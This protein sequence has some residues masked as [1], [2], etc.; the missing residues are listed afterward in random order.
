MRT[1]LENPTVSAVNS[2]FGRPAGAARV[3]RWV[4]FALCLVDSA[5]L[6]ASDVAES[7][8]VAIGAPVAPLIVAVTDGTAT[9]SGRLQ[10]LVDADPQDR[11]RISYPAVAPEGQ[12]WVDV[13]LRLWRMQEDGQVALGPAGY[14]RPGVHAFDALGGRDG[15]LLLAV[16]SLRPS[17]SIGDSHIVIESLDGSPSTSWCF[18]VTA[19]RID[20]DADTDRSGGIDLADEVGEADW[21]RGVQG[22]GVIILPNCDR[23]GDRQGPP[24]NWAGGDWDGDG[25]VDAVEEPNGRI[26]GPK[27]LADIGRVVLRRFGPD[28]LPPGLTVQLRLQAVAPDLPFDQGWFEMAFV[29]EEDSYRSDREAEEHSGDQWEQDENGDRGA[30]GDGDVRWHVAEDWPPD[31][32]APDLRSQ[33]RW[34][35]DRPARY[36]VR[37][38]WPTQ[39]SGDRMELGPA[40]RSVLGPEHATD[41]VSLAVASLAGIGEVELGVE[42]IAFGALVDLVLSVRFQGQVVGEDRLRLRVA[43]FVLSDHRQGVGD[44]DLRAAWVHVNHDGRNNRDL[45]LALRQLYSAARVDE[46]AMQ[47]L[48]HQDGYEVGYVKAPYGGMPVVLE[49]ARGVDWSEGESLIDYVRSQVL[50]PGIGVCGDLTRVEHNSSF[51][52]GGNIECMPLG[53]GPGAF[54]YGASMSRMLIAF[55]ATQGVNPL[56]PVDTDWLSVGHIDEV[57][58]FTGQDTA[59][60]ADP[61]TALALL[62]WAWQMQPEAVL[63]IN[64]T[65]DV[66]WCDLRWYPWYDEERCGWRDECD[67]EEEEEQGFGSAG[68]EADVEGDAEASTSR[69]SDADRA[70]DDESDAVQTANRGVAIGEKEGRDTEVQ[71]EGREVETEVGGEV[72][73]DDSFDVAED[74][75]GGW[76][77]NRV[78]VPLEVLLDVDSELRNYNLQTIMSEDELGGVRDELGLKHYASR[79]QP[80]PANVGDL[81]LQRGGALLAWLP[82]SVTRRQYR[83]TYLDTERYRI[84]YRDLHAEPGPWQAGAIGPRNGD[85]TDPQSLAFIFREWWS[86]G[87][88]SPGDAYFFTVRARPRAIPIPVLFHPEIDQA[89]AL[90]ANAVNCILDGTLVI[91][92]LPVGPTVDYRG[93]GR[94]GDI[95]ADYVR[96]AFKRLGMHHVALVDDSAYHDRDGSL[97]CATNVIRRVPEDDWWRYAAPAQSLPFDDT[98]DDDEAVE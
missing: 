80:G 18:A 22:R 71:E 66:E 76:P 55:F 2:R 30:S 86:D 26:D 13:G 60:L 53:A 43:P 62:V 75:D 84:D 19:L 89:R 97:H 7:G 28:R 6:Q 23:E 11:F 27:D 61:E 12:R 79:P 37:V 41:Q 40:D 51:D 10:L 88:V 64:Q 56:R 25:V 39:L 17:R 90:T 1:L 74:E 36:R 94:R 78:P 96:S 9:A 16:E 69:R 68:S 24:D 92:A 65:T 95:L 8:A 29:E 85:C 35:I 4:V 93:N 31:Q 49:L 70:A 73:E 63:P 57:V 59:A 52:A 81:Q 50:S 82:Q 15:R 21:T 3:G 83:L 42:G 34:L 44:D 54:V 72:D 87:T 5:D 67:E 38:F 91:A 45:R 33:P 46:P 47:D 98:V 32:V 58:A 77:T 14:V 48:W 20:L